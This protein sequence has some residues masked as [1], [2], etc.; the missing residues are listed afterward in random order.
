LASSRGRNSRGGADVALDAL[1]RTAEALTG[2]PLP[3]Q[4][5]EQFARYLDLLITWNRTQRLTAFESPAEI[6]RGLLADALLFLGLLPPRPIKVADL[7]AGAGIPGLPLRIVDP[8]V[9]L[10][11]VEARR[12]RVSFLKTVKRELR[13]D[14]VAIFEGRAEAIRD[15]VVGARGLFDCV[16]ARSVAPIGEL[17]PVALG[18]LKPGGRLVASAPPPG[19]G[20]S[21][22]F[23]GASTDV[24]HFPALGLERAFVVVTKPS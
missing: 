15:E 1:G 21:P 23:P 20:W 3:R 10:T 11:L 9:V 22:G 18:Y 14:D 2:H 4:A 7:G 5:R 16:V 13:L 8:G 19:S 17:A 12:R 6:V 24:R